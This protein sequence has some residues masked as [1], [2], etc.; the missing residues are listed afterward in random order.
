MGF[1]NCGRLW[2]NAI[3]CFDE[4]VL[5]CTCFYF[6]RLLLHLLFA[7]P[8]TSKEKIFTVCFFV[9]A[10]VC[11]GHVYQLFYSDSF[12]LLH[13]LFSHDLQHK[14][15]MSNFNTRWGMVIAII[16][17]GIKST[18]SWYLQQKENLEILKKKT[19]AEMQLQKSRIHPQ[20]LLRSLDSIYINIQKRSGNASTM[21]LNLSGLL[22]YSLYEAGCGTGAVR[23]GVAATEAFN[24]T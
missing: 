14:I 12:S 21:I 4:P 22:C 23:K 9:S 13:K 17:L 3:H 6:S 7:A 5:L 24:F 15:E 10:G 16:A 2:T 8:D 20:L 11:S 19:R 18:K 1:K